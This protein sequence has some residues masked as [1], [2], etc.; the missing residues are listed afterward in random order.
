MRTFAVISVNKNV[1]L[2]KNILSRL[3]DGSKVVVFAAEN[4]KNEEIDKL[5]QLEG[6]R[7]DLEVRH[8]PDELVAHGPKLKNFVS[9]SFLDDKTAGFL[10]VIEDEVEIFSSPDVFLDEIERMMKT[11]G[12]KSWFNTSCDM[13]NYVYQKYVPR[14]YVAI[15]E[16]NAKAKYDKTLAWCSNANTMWICYDLDSATMEDIR[17]EE[18]FDIPMYY[19]IEFLA[20]R[21]N[22]KKPGSLDYMNLYPS[23]PEELNVFRRADIA[24]NDPFTQE[25]FSR[26][27]EIFNKMNV[28]NSPD[29]NV[30][31]VLENIRRFLVES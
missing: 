19:I 4:G 31:D 13:C 6:R 23:I 25:D 2:D 3:P 24:V 17:F 29:A 30:D 27:G 1:N 7:L 15:D 28:N 9:K 18:S 8:Y 22:V 21:R 20:R 10:H 26:E 11:F 16:E 5:A 14:F 12:L